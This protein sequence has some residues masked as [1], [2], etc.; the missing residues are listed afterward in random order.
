MDAKL[1]KYTIKYFSLCLKCSTYFPSN[2]S[3]KDIAEMYMLTN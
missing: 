2:D 3:G 1:H